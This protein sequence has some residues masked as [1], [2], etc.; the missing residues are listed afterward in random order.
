MS[1]HVVIGGPRGCGKSTLTASLFKQLEELGV[2]AGVHE[3]DVYSDTIPCILGLK[4]W[5]KRK[6]K[7]HAWFTPTICRRIQ[8]YANDKREIV[9]G[10]LPGK[11]TNQFLSRMVEPADRAIIVAK[12][13]D[14]V[15][16]WDTFFD[17]RNIPVA[18]RVISYREQL[19]LLP[20]SIQNVYFVQ[21][22]DRKVLLNPEIQMIAQ[23][24]RSVCSQSTLSVLRTG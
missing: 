16:E 22:L 13:W 17:K 23:Q 20:P 12:D 18:L 4:P 5:E 19:P 15:D 3:I 9:L 14:S 8:E 2:G 1:T 6:K 24:L 21:N 7:K 10:D 11:M